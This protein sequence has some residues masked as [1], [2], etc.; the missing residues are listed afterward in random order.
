[1]KHLLSKGLLIVVGLALLLSIPLMALRMEQAQVRKEIAAIRASEKHADGG[2]VADKIVVDCFAEKT[3][4]YTGG[5]Y[6]NELIR[7]R[8]RSPKRIVP[9]QKYP[10][11]VWLHGKGESGDENTRQLSHVQATM[12][13][14]D[15]E[16]EL[17][18][19]V[20][21]TQCPKDNRDWTNSVSPDGKGDA[22]VTILN[23]I[24][25]AVLGEH[26]I[27][28][29]RIGLVG[30]CSGGGGA[31]PLLEARPGFFSGVVVFSTAPPTGFDWNEQYRN[32]SL[33]AFTNLDDTAV[34]TPE[35]RRFVK[36]V[37]RSGGLA[38]LTTRESGGHDSWTEAM[39]SDKV[40]AWLIHRDLQHRSPPPGLVM[41]V[42]AD[43]KKP[44]LYFGLP[45]VL[46]GA[47]SVVR[48]RQWRS[49]RK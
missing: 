37:N 33:W 18:F 28:R 40:I 31:W 38:H 44:F 11:V 3:Y 20:L 24:L 15:G 21:A 32:T 29:N 23:E 47:V 26:P 10:L 16:N 13:F 1:M 22:P 2:Y 6:E 12:E 19:F 4:R 8:F 46:I 25:D 7:Y 45:L 30:L 17:D 43:G 5:R 49:L 48:V 9:G 39:R 34:S 41:H 27:D 42:R 35:M 14:L 36:Q